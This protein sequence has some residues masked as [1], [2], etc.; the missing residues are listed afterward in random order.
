[1][2]GDVVLPSTTAEDWPALR[3]DI[4]RR[5]TDSMGEPPDDAPPP[6]SSP[7]YEETSRAERDGLVHV[8][9]R[10][11]VLADEWNEGVL[12][13]PAGGEGGEGGEGGGAACPARAVLTIHGTNAA[14]GRRGVLDA[15]KPSRAYGLELARRGFVT[16]SVD[17]FGFGETLAGTAQPELYERFYRDYPEWSLDGRRVLDQTRAMDVLD[18]LEVVDSSGDSPYG[19][20]G[21][22]QGGRAVM[23]TAALDERV[24]AGVSSTGISPNFSNAFRSVTWDKVLSP[25]LSEEINRHGRPGWDYHEMIALVAPRALLALEPYNDVAGCNPDVGPTMECVYR[26]ARVFRLLGVPEHLALL[27]HGDGHTTTGDVRD[28]AYRW[29]ER[30]L[31]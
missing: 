31:K 25:R 9:L 27:V 3:A 2:L 20:I 17:Q 10:Y 30:F 5:V 4:L 15:E 21:N 13:L 26:A 1:M 8:G 6:G 23:Y 14:A 24:G 28:F 22:S 7:E 29:L 11:R 12:V 19:A 16:F 18:A